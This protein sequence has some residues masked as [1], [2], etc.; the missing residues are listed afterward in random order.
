MI[1]YLR[2]GQSQEYYEALGYQ[3]LEAPWWVPAGIMEI[4]RPEDRT[5]DSI[6]FLPKNQKALVAS[7]EQSL[8]Y[9]ANQ[10]LLPKGMYQTVTPC[11]RDEVQSPL[12]RKF[13]MKN[14][15]M[16]ANSSSQNDLEKAIDNALS[17]YKTQVPDLN[18][19]AVV[20]TKEGFD[21]EYAGI[22]IGSY[23][24]RSCSF[25]DWIYATGLAEPR[26]SRAIKSK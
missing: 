18:K 25:L 24:I 22:E 5:E 11:F 7:G 26:F 13:F 1:N 19:L 21:I 6:Y 10:G 2:L 16:I 3:R 23:G 8:L 14:E 17:F 20:T 9:L 4:T 12:R 15:L